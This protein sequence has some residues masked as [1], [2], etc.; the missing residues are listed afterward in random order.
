[1]EEIPPEATNYLIQAG[2]RRIAFV[3]T[4]MTGEGEDP[5]IPQIGFRFG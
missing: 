3:S 1:M 4:L 5:L 2:H